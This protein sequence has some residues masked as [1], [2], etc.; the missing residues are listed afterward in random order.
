MKERFWNFYGQIGARLTRDQSVRGSVPKDTPWLVKIV[1]PALF[2]RVAR[3]LN[4]LEKIWI[5]GVIKER[6]WK[7]FMEDLEKEWNQSI[8]MVCLF[9][10]CSLDFRAAGE[11]RMIKPRMD[12]DGLF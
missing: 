6:H 9:V 5:D 7:Q 2:L 4:T 10:S 1:G 12:I 8:V 3:Y 11:N